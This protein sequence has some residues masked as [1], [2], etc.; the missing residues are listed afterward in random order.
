M[1]EIRLILRDPLIRLCAI[2]CAIGFGV[3]VFWSA[4]APLD[5][6]VVAS[7]QLVV[8]G[9]RKSIAHFEG[10][11]VQTIHV[12]EGQRV[13][14]DERLL[15]LEPVQSE[16]ER[17]EIA[18]SLFSA[19]ASLARLSALREGS[20][21]VFDVV[22]TEISGA[23]A[24]EIIAQQRRLFFQQRAALEAELAFLAT[25]RETSEGRAADLDRQLSV[26]NANLQVARGDLRRR[27]T[28]LAEQ[29]DIIDN[30]QRA[31]R[32]VFSLEAESARLTTD[33][34]LA[35][36]D[37]LETDSRT[38]E[39]LSRTQRERE[40]EAAEAAE[41]ALAFQERLEANDDRLDRTVITAPLSGL[42]LGLNAN[43]IG[44]VVR[45]GEIVMEIVPDDGSLIALLRIKPIDREA[46]RQG[47]V[48]RAQLS[49]YK[50]Y[51]VPRIEGEVMSVS[52]DLREDAQTGL[53]Y[54]EAR[55][56]LDRETLRGLPTVELVPGLPVDAFI[57]SGRQRTFLDYV[58]EPI[59]STVRKGLAL[60]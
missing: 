55:V 5:E 31:E 19:R 21:P 45:P 35:Q 14:E 9:E 48:V 13:E 46:V 27:R 32:E 28:G 11:I 58:L 36:R 23:I 51:R 43:T 10:G 54:Y 4:L 41:M 18:Q 56:R 25:Q 53:S 8:R 40:T 47:Q 22:T 16:A 60:N 30:V 1:H 26:V 7:G 52:A 44:G 37:V 24:D 15:T 57:A 42:V 49:A 3:F 12:S 33:R 17:D 6:G 2:A 39:L 38:N 20:E 34:N 59:A 50:Q 29:L